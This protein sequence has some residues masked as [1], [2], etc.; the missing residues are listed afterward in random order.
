MSAAP[1]RIVTGHDA[2]GKSI[3]LSDAATPKT[4]DIG[5]AAFHEIWITAQTPV[6]IAATEPEPT[7][8]RVRTPEPR[9]GVGDAVVQRGT[10]HA[11]ANRSERPVRMLFVLIDATVSDELRAAAGPLEFF[12]QVLD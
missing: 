7:E 6:E 11:W 5:T 9:V 12:D 3:V 2:S 4:L 10:N 1:R 8:R